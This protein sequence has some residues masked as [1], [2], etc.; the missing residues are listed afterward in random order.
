MIQQTV[1]L[2]NVLRSLF[3]HNK[4]IGR[5]CPLCVQNPF[6]SGKF[7]CCIR[8]KTDGGQQA[9]IIKIGIIKI[10]LGTFY[11]CTS[12]NFFRSRKQT[13]TQRDNCQNRNITAQTLPYLA[14]GG[15]C[16]IEDPIRSPSFAQ[17]ILLVR[18]AQPV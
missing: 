4:G 11:H 5:D 7:P 17:Q 12:G 3:I 1:Y 14:Q 9:H 18:S 6:S 13:D 10:L 2:Q 16:G 15:L 8:I